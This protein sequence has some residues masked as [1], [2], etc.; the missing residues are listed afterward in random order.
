MFVEP[1]EQRFE[2]EIDHKR[3]DVH[4]DIRDDLLLKDFSADLPAHISEWRQY[5]SAVK[6]FRTLSVFGRKLV[7]SVA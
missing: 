5:N 3:F 7:D 6:H 2:I 4:R 1:A